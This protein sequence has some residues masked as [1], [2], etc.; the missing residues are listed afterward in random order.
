MLVEIQHHVRL[1]FGQQAEAAR[2]FLIGFGFAAGVAA[3]A[4]L[5]DRG[6]R[7]CGP[8]PAESAD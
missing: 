6:C 5:R 1:A 4:V 2:D 3:E 8:P 7:R